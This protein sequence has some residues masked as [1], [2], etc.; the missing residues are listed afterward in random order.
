MR[1]SKVAISGIVALSMLAVSST[2]Y[3]ERANSSEVITSNNSTST[4]NVAASID[5]HNKNSTQLSLSPAA[6]NAASPSANS[7]DN[8]VSTSVLSSA[9]VSSSNTS[10]PA[11]ASNNSTTGSQLNSASNTPS[12]TPKADTKPAEAVQQTPAPAPEA[13]KPAPPSN[14]SS[15]KLVLGYGTYYSSSDV[16]SLNSLKAHSSSIDQLA[17][18]TYIIKTDGSMYIQN[19]VF[20]TAQIS[21]ANSKGIETLAVIRNEFNGASAHD[22]LNNA[23]ASANLINNIE[24][25][26][27]THGY[28]GVNI[29]FELL[30]AK[31]REVF[32]SFMRD[33]YNRLKPKCYIVSIALPAKTSEAES[34]VKAYDYAKLGSYSDLVILM[35]YDEHY[36]GGAP[37][38]VASL[39]WTQRIVT[40]AASVIPRQKLLLGLAAYG[41]DWTVKDGKTI[42]TKSLGIQSS[43]N[44][45]SA[46]GVQ[47]LWDETAKSPYYNYTDAK[48]NHTVYFENS[49]SIDYKL[50]IV[51]N[52]NLRGIAIWRL[53]LEDSSYWTTIKE[54]L[55]K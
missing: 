35:T 26:L 14:P 47:V 2:A 44:V 11:A 19:N 51:N 42:S 40:Y 7:T 3:L 12:T 52:S 4:N 54:K 22:V 29:D 5:I 18:H 45:A 31:D 46:N 34:W 20:P 21:Y 48:G 30:Y 27:G 41:Y 36:P 9:N 24:S 6:N 15:S 38:P 13:P 8:S 39:N 53:G 23:E 32:T 50:N 10:T 33:L 28:K 17:T 49:T 1:F 16:S 37:G 25:A 55:N 43:Y